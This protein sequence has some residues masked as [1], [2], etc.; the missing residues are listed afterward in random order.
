M[1]IHIISNGF[2][3]GLLTYPTSQAI[4]QLNLGK[5]QNDEKTYLKKINP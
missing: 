4:M 3:F 5:T 1:V 2:L